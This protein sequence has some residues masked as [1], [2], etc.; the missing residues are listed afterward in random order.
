MVKDAPRMDVPDDE[1]SDSMKDR[2]PTFYRIQRWTADMLIYVNER[3]GKKEKEDDE[4]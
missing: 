4:K 2:L 1:D 3:K